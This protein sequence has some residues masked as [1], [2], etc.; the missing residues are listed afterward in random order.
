MAQSSGCEKNRKT[1]KASNF[2]NFFGALVD[3]VCLTIRLSTFAGIKTPDRR[4]LIDIL[5]ATECD[6]G[7]IHT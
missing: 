2:G 3:P 7:A 5:I 4:H 1:E 6:F